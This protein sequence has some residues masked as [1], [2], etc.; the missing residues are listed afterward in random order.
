MGVVGEFINVLLQGE[1]SRGNLIGIQLKWL[2][3]DA[4]L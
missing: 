2:A 3:I 4:F 1:L